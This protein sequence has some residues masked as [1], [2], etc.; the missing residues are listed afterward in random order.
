MFLTITYNHN[1]EHIINAAR[2]EGNNDN[3]WEHI[4]LN[5]KSTE[6]YVQTSSL[7][8]RFFFLRTQKKMHQ[9]LYS[10][11]TLRTDIN[12]LIIPQL[13]AKLNEPSFMPLRMKQV[14]HISVTPSR[15]V[16]N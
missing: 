2:R 1:P 14:L 10:I 16:Q 11:H 7:L 15:F 5:K 13:R 9:I 8:F 4:G 6:I 12:I 3:V